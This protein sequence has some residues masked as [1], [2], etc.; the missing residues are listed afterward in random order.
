MSDCSRYWDRAD[1]ILLND[2]V[3]Y[4]CEWSGHDLAHCREAKKAAICS[5]ID[6]GS[7]HFRRRD[8]KPQQDDIYELA[9]RNQL[10][11]ERETFFSWVQQFADAPKPEKQLG[12]TEKNSLLKLVIGMAIKGYGYD[13]E[14]KRSDVPSEIAGDLVKLGLS[15]DVDTVRKYLAMAATDVLDR[16]PR[17]P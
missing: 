14:A 7:I 17:Q 5:A 12:T 2:V 3:S 6:K 1:H 16:K 15:I 9:A 4:W 8:G 11:V 13:V 10:L